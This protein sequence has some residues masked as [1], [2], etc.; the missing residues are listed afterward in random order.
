MKKSHKIPLKW[1]EVAQMNLF[2]FRI[3]WGFPQYW[4]LNTPHTWESKLRCYI[5]VFPVLLCWGYC[6]SKWVLSH[7]M[8]YKTFT[9]TRTAMSPF[10][11][12]ELSQFPRIMLN[13]FCSLQI[14]NDITAC[15]P[16][17]TGKSGVGMGPG[18]GGWHVPH[19]YLKMALRSRTGK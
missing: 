12:Q 4:L 7:C 6:S 13:L 2:P 5:R 17:P 15:K 11:P 10:M 18:G 16:R 8:E 3:T 1:Y 14:Q 9:H 19:W